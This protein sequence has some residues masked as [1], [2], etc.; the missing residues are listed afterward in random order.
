MPSAVMAPPNA[1]AS[2]GVSRPSGSGRARV[3]SMRASTSRSQYWL[4]ASVPPAAS[5]V[6]TARWT[7][8]AQSG[9]P[10]RPT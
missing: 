6:P 1:S 10:A 2:S 5:T 3:R 4:S 8:R 7:S 9:A